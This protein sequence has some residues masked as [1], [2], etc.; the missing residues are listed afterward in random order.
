MWWRLLRGGQQHHQPAVGNPGPCGHLLFGLRFRQRRHRL[1][2]ADGA[3][4]RGGRGGGR[5]VGGNGGDDAHGFCRLRAMSEKESEPAGAMRPFDKSRD[6]F[7][8]GEGAA[9]LVLEELSQAAGRGAQN[10]RRVC[11]ATGGVRDAYHATDPHPEGLGYGL[12]LE[13]AL[14]KARLHPTKWT[15][16]MRMARRPR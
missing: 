5:G 8:L 13:K 2:G 6:G 11:R 7:V 15:T 10:L 16:S 3:G 4:G 14:R 9:F 1:R 12:A